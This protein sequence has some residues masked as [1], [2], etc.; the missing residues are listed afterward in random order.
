MLPKSQQLHAMIHADSRLS[1]T[2]QSC[3]VTQTV[4]F[5]RSGAI[6]CA[7]CTLSGHQSGIFNHGRGHDG[8][9][10]AF[11][12]IICEDMYAAKSTTIHEFPLSRSQLVCGLAPLNHRVLSM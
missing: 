2:M 9:G 8:H 5:A 7:A 11:I 3:A 10:T 1:N 6:N 12:C 4:A